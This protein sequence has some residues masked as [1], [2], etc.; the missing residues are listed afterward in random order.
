M[1]NLNSDPN[2]ESGSLRLQPA[3]H[4]SFHLLPWNPFLLRPP[5]PWFLLH[6]GTVLSS[7]FL[8]RHT[9]QLFL[10]HHLSS[11]VF[12]TRTRFSRFL[13]YMFSFQLT[14]SFFL[15]W[16]YCV[17][18]CHSKVK[19]I[20]QKQMSVLQYTLRNISFWGKI[21]MHLRAIYSLFL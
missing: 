3:L 21:Q 19:A 14:F 12:R 10:H 6:K 17:C 4:L 16:D 13:S 15:W 11:L 5:P 9:T 2:S 18:Y 8:L 7:Y 1:S 20:Y